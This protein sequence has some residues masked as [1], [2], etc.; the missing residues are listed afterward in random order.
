MAFVSKRLERGLGRG[1]SLEATA[2]LGVGK[3]DYPDGGMFEAGQAIYSRGSASMIHV[4]E[5]TTRLTVEQPLR[6]E[7][8]QATL[9]YPVRRTLAGE[10]V[11][12]AQR[13]AL[14]PGGREV[15]LAVS[16]QR[17]VGPGA[18]LIEAGYAFDRGHQEGGPNDARI[19]LGY[20]LQW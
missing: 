2:G 12:T 9:V 17:R 11:Y 4:G 20:R 5:G 10:R 7:G 16:H 14:R 18:G 13:V 1:W 15:R 6:A 3:T 8:G 19:F